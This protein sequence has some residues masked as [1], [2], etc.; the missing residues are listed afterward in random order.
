MGF[1]EKLKNRLDLTSPENREKIRQQL[2]I[3]FPSELANPF[4]D[5]MLERSY[6]DNLSDR[7]SFQ[8]VEDCCTVAWIRI[9]R[10][11][12]HP[13]N[14]EEYDLL[15]RWQAVLSS[16]HSWNERVLFLLR[17]KDGATSI[18]LG[19]QGDDME[20]SLARLETALVNSLPGI[21]SSRIGFQEAMDIAGSLTK[22]KHCGAVTGIPS[23]RKETRFQ[24]LQTLDSLAFGIRD[25]FG[26]DAD[27][28][29]MVVAEPISDEGISDIISRMMELGTDIHKEVHKSYNSQEG[30][31]KGSNQTLGIAGLL[32]S[33]AAVVPTTGTVLASW[34]GSDV[35]LQKS[36]SISF[37]LSET[38]DFLNKFAE[39]TERIIDTHCDRLRKGRNLG[40]WNAGVYV[41]SNDE[42]NTGTVLGMLRSVYSGDESFIEPIRVHRFKPQSGAAEVVSNMSLIPLQSEKT[43]E[44]EWHIFGKNY[45]YVSTP[46]NTQ[47]LSLFTS[48]PRKDVP[49]LRFVK[50]AVRF[51]NNPGLQSGKRSLVLGKIKDYGV[52]QKTDYKIDI[53]ALV[54]HSLI[55]GGTGSGKSTTCRRLIQSAMDIGAP[56]LIIEPAKE[57]YTR[58]FLELRK[59]GKQVNIF[60]PGATAFEGEKLGRLKLN[61]FQPAA[62]P[63]ATIDMMTRCE[64][65]T[66][67]VNASLPSSDVLPVIMDET[68]FT[69]LKDQPFGGDFMQGEM[70]QLENYPKIEGA[71]E[72]AKRVLKARGYTD[73]VSQGIGAAVETRLTYLSR[74]KRGE[75][76]NVFNSTP[77]DQ[78]FDQTT[79]I[80]LSRLANPKDRALIMSIILLALHEYRVSR[81]ST[82]EDYRRKAGSNQLM[83]LTVVEE[84]HNVLAAPAADAQGTG[85]PQQ[86]VADLFSNMLSEIRAYGEGLMIVDQSPTKLIP[87]VIKNTNYKIAHRMTARDDCA[88]MASALALRDEQAGIIPTLEIGNAI[89]YGD[90]D[91]AASW[92]KVNR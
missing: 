17:R 12:I 57:E 11:P 20:G 30:I 90:K 32:Q 10:L 45:Q 69:F 80:N 50:T 74:G 48:L 13:S 78:L 86:V 54:R 21:T 53:D 18:Y 14:S 24:D 49:G 88:V 75:I 31:N 37:S 91:D 19:L 22:S 79:V 28:S 40:F 61:P 34:V 62:V 59:A 58:W 82:D 56:I 25:V 76:L 70:N 55:V 29:V 5:Y 66:A 26:R 87:D 46:V 15:S 23:F 9:D 42:H 2:P 41:L 7:D 92:V 73:E 27:F 81:F 47:E 36:K 43:E 35:Q 39:Y 51:A 1:V 3:Q 33:L 65:L 16:L 4:I 68:F 72:T 84:A 85:N 52:E 71:I 67:L 83:H 63:G 60:M 38:T 64:Q 8:M 89:I 77:W 44:K 6:L